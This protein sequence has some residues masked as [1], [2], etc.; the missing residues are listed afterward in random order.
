MCFST[1]ILI[2]LFILSILIV[3]FLLFIKR[4]KIK[5]WNKTIAPEFLDSIIPPENKFYIQPSKYQK[6]ENEEYIQKYS[7]NNYYQEYSENLQYPP[8]TQHSED[9]QERRENHIHN[10]NEK[11]QSLENRYREAQNQEVQNQEVQNQEVQNQEVQNQEV[12]NQE[13]QNVSASVVPMNTLLN[14]LQNKNKISPKE[15]NTPLSFTILSFNIR[16]DV[17]K[18]PHN[19][20]SRKY[21]VLHNINIYKPSIICLQE[22][23]EKVKKFI[24]KS[25]SFDGVGSY[26]DSS[27]RAEAGHVIFDPKQW[28]FVSHKSFVYTEDGIKLCGQVACSSVTVFNGVKDKHT[29]I[30]THVV[31]RGVN[32]INVINTHFPLDGTLQAEC[33]KQLIAYINKLSTPVVITGDFNSHYLP[34]S[35]GTPLDNLMTSASLLDANNL[36][37]IPTFGTFKKIRSNVNKLDYILYRGMSTINAGVSDYRYGK[38]QFRPSDHQALFASFVLNS[39]LT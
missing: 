36:E 9:K 24:C 3:G 29:R 12:Q 2:T 10:K 23:T 14:I 20:D 6:L 30:F 19:W 22:S 16:C 7:E 11:A 27:S 28:K 33:A 37:N 17:D 26:R 1:W 15:L 21:E 18:V 31:L 38:E 4:K 5:K 34:T 8:I 39:I 35:K 25:L 13:V 32:E